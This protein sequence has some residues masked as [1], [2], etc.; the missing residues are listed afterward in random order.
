LVAATCQFLIPKAREV[1]ALPAQYPVHLLP[2]IIDN[3]VKSLRP[4]F[5]FL[6]RLDPVKRPWIFFALA[7]KFPQ[8]D[9]LVMGQP[10]FLEAQNWTPAVA[11][12]NLKLLGHIDGEDK[13]EALASLS[14]VSP[15]MA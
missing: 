10:H 1:L 9:F 5:G 4:S 2:N 7:Q 13:S 12:A 11:P 8:A 3:I 6:G 15:A 14:A